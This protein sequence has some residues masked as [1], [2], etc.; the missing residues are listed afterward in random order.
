[1]DIDL[2]KNENRTFLS[3]LRD[4]SSSTAE[5]VS[6][7]LRQRFGRFQVHAGH[8]HVARHPWHHGADQRMAVD[9]RQR[10]VPEHRLQVGHV[11]VPRETEVL[12]HQGPLL[13]YV[14][15]PVDPSV[16]RDGQG[17]FGP[18]QERHGRRV[19][20]ARV[21]DVR[22]IV[23]VAVPLR[24]PGVGGERQHLHHR[25]PVLVAQR[26]ET[27]VEKVLHHHQI[28]P[29]VIVQDELFHGL[30]FQRVPR[31]DRAQPQHEYVHRQPVDDAVL[32]QEVQACN[33]TIITMQ[34]DASLMFPVISTVR[35]FSATDLLLRAVYKRLTKEHR[36]LIFSH[37]HPVIR[38]IFHTFIVL[39]F[40][41]L[42]V[43]VINNF[44]F[45]Y[46][47]ETVFNI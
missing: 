18:L 27:L 3:F 35:I 25:R 42:T 10:H 36:M 17:V 47:L 45:L 13:R 12:T 4:S 40:S 14:H 22:G 26:H 30:V 24:H 16:E 28:V 41:D 5:R 19:T 33:E 2:E 1:M 32:V 7:H 9:Q 15:Q 23:R 37:T 46:D 44:F 8:F 31:Y 43:L 39:F 6:T 21:G 34:F 38:F 20:A 11:L 29:T